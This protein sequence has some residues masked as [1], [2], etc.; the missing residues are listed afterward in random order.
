MA[1]RPTSGK[2]KSARR[3]KNPVDKYLTNR[4]ARKDFMAARY[5]LGSREDLTQQKINALKK[6]TSVQG[7]L[8]GSSY[9]GKTLGAADNSGWVKIMQGFFAGLK[10]V[11]DTYKHGPKELR[12]AVRDAEN[13]E[14]A[15]RM[16][17]QQGMN[18]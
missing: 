18:M 4:Q 7:V 15:R 8:T 17:E 6:E 11:Q 10:E 13:K 5:P 16:L 14:R 3:A 12:D 1:K 2:V 9:M